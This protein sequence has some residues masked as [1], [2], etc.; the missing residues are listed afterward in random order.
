[1]TTAKTYPY[2]IISHNA[3]RNYNPTIVTSLTDDKS[4]HIKKAYG[5]YLT[6]Y[7]QNGAEMEGGTFSI[8]SN[9]SNFKVS[10]SK[11]L[12]AYS[13]D[14]LAPASTS[15]EIE[16]KHQGSLTPVETK[17]TI[18]RYSFIEDTTP[19]QHQNNFD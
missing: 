14:A 1:V 2:K 9:N 13:D 18:E 3:S 11:I 6:A 15:F 10:S 12:N 5:Y 17:K 16:Y 19:E 7:D 4:L 8:P